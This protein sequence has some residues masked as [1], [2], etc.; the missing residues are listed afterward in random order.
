MGKAYMVAGQAGAC[1]HAMALSQA[2]QCDLLKDLDES[3]GVDLDTNQELCQATDL[4]LLSHRF[5]PL[6]SRPGPSA[7]LCQPWWPQRCICGWT[8]PTSKRWHSQLRSHHSRVIRK[9]NEEVGVVW[10]CAVVH[11]DCNHGF[12]RGN[13]PLRRPAILPASLFRS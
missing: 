6:R 10:R 12:P 2:Y 8:C 7:I 4:S 13:K 5:V 3:K 1:L 11:Y 9:F